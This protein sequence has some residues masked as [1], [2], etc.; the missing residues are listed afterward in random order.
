[1]SV[2]LESLETAKNLQL[3][4]ME[5]PIVC[6]CEDQN[7]EP[8]VDNSDGLFQKMNSFICKFSAKDFWDF[9]YVQEKKLELL[10]LV[11]PKGRRDYANPHKYFGGNFK[12]SSGG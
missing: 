6:K 1:M 12:G 4:T 9:I 8:E 10:R 11:L 7:Y 3:C 2:A 5:H